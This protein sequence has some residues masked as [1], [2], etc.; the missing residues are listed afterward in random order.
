MVQNSSFCYCKHHKIISQYTTLGLGLVS[1]DSVIYL[2][3]YN[4]TST[5][6][7]IIIHMLTHYTVDV[8]MKTTYTRDI[9][10]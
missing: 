3:M 4:I 6:V 5:I 2:Y 1:L 7:Y 9:F 10:N 8:I